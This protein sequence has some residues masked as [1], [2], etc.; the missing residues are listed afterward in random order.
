MAKKQVNQHKDNGI[1]FK[2]ENSAC[3]QSPFAARS[4]YTLILRNFFLFI[5]LFIEFAAVNACQETVFVL[6]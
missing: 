2:E 5:K 3:I 1:P 6:K 4:D